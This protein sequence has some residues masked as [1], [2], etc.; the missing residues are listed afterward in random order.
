MLAA[1]RKEGLDSDWRFVPCP[2]IGFIAPTWH[3]QIRRAN[4]QRDFITESCV[5]S[6]RSVSKEWPLGSGTARDPSFRSLQDSWEMQ[7]DSFAKIKR[8]GNPNPPRPETKCDQS[9]PHNI[10]PVPQRPREHVT[11]RMLNPLRSLNPDWV[12]NKLNLSEVVVTQPWQAS[13]TKSA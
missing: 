2:C 10:S 11:R 7:S 4:L 3:G 9:S 13:T 6:Q 1:P 12:P 5:R 8:V